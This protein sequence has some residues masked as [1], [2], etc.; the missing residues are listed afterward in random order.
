MTATIDPTD[1]SVTI[2]EALYDDMTD[3][4]RKVDEKIFVFYIPLTRE[5]AFMVGAKFDQETQLTELQY[6]PKTRTVGFE[7]LNP[8]V[9]RICYDYG[10]ELEKPT[11]VGV[12]KRRTGDMEY[13]VLKPAAI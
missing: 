11:T 6:N 7:T 5:Y 10:L 12:E 2:C 13:Y 4:D 3:H 8:T 1:N 9:V